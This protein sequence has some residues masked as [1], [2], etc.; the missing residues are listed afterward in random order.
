MVFGKE[1]KLWL[2]GTHQKIGSA[3]D[4]SPKRAQ[5]LSRD[6]RGTLLRCDNLTRFEAG[7][8]VEGFIWRKLG[9][10]TTLVKYGIH[11]LGNTPQ[12]LSR[13]PES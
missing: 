7:Y 2:V 11:S 9:D 10:R 6:K 8:A 3:L 1:F 13:P 4:S 5:L 12:I